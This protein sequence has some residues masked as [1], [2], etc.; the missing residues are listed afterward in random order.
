MH[1]SFAFIS[2]TR[3]LISPGTKPLCPVSSYYY[4]QIE[5]ESTALICFPLASQCHLYLS[6]LGLIFSSGKLT[7][8]IYLLGV[9]QKLL[10]VW[11]YLIEFYILI[12]IYL[13][14]IWCLKNVMAY[15]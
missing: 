9:L 6:T 2:A 13:H 11:K 5:V 1:L 14:W 4:Y 10:G 12:T 8:N 3:E 7:K 15:F